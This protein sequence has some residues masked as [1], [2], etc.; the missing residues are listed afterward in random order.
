[1][2]EDSAAEKG[3]AQE[4]PYRSAVQITDE[5]RQHCHIYLDEQLCTFPP[6]STKS[7]LIS[8]RY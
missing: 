6:H 4:T 1:M 3:A 8:H 7:L 2:S 5:L